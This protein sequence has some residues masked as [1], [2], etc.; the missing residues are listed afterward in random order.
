MQAGL[1]VSAVVADLMLSVRSG[2]AFD[3]TLIPVADSVGSGDLDQPNRP[4]A[5]SELIDAS[6]WGFVPYRRLVLT[7]ELT[8]VR[9]LGQ[10]P[11]T[12]LYEEIQ[13]V[14]ISR[15]GLVTSKLG[16]M[17]SL[18]RS[19]RLYA[20]ILA[21]HL[22]LLGRHDSLVFRIGPS[23]WA[24]LSDHWELAGFLTWPVYGPDRLGAWDGMYGTIAAVYRFATQDHRSPSL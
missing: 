19:R 16:P 4:A 8:Y 3:H 7:W 13:R 24:G 10:S 14:V 5:E 20:G 6:L 18:L 12:L 1:H 23:V 21:E 17:V 15:Q 9:P 11:S 22:S 2:Y